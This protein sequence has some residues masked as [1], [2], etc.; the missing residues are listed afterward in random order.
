MERIKMM[1]FLKICQWAAGGCIVIL[2]VAT[3]FML[4]LGLT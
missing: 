4:V 2:V 1:Q 3:V